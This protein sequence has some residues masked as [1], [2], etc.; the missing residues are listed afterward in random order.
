ML[1]GNRARRRPLTNC[2][3]RGR[4]EHTV[5]YAARVKTELRPGFSVSNGSCHSRARSCGNLRGTVGT[6]HGATKGPGTAPSQVSST[7][8]ARKPKLPKLSA[9]NPSVVGC[10]SL[11]DRMLSRLSHL[12]GVGLASLRHGRAAGQRLHRGL[13]SHAHIQPDT[14]C[15]DC[16]VIRQQRGIRVSYS[17]RL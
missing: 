1:S 6:G 10:F 17:S 9:G 15:R 2:L 14:V 12:L 13:L 3:V 7:A 16:C 5:T 4:L 11:R 8:A